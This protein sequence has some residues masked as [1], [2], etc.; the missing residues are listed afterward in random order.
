ML[1]IFGF[2]VQLEEFACVFIFDFNLILCQYENYHELKNVIV[3][4]DTKSVAYCTTEYFM[5]NLSNSLCYKKRKRE[6]S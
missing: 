5:N 4:I 2:L 3:T 6:Y 1:I